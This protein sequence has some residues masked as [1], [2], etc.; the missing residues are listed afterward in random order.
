MN[1]RRLRAALAAAALT[2]AAAGAAAA[3][4]AGQAAAATAPR[5]A[6]HATS[7]AKVFHSVNGK[8]ASWLGLG[9]H[10]IQGKHALDHQE[11][12][13]NWA[14][15]AADSTTYTSASA[16]WKQPSVDCSEGSGYSAFWVGIDG[17]NSSTVEQ[18]GT[19]A[20]CSGGS[21]SYSAWYEAYPAASNTYSNTVEPG[22]S[23]TATVTESSG[24][25]FDLVLTDSTQGWTENTDVT[26]SGA[27]SSSAEVI[28]EAPSSELGVLP[29][30]DFGTVNFTNAE[31]NST[32]FDSLS[33]VQIDMESAFGQLEASTS[34]LSDDDFSVTWE[35][36]GGP[37]LPFAR[38]G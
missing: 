5:T 6:E 8:D 3:A 14:G 38:Q 17:F 22:D 36:S 26:V 18:T 1:R 37:S 13:E 20:D 4:G 21:A 35:S 33:P 16:S 10:T 27:E 34:S 28:A 32:G 15:Y 19:E 25:V 31:A 23:L 7:T 12:S 29:L 30:A 11:Y 2:V 9:P 24:D